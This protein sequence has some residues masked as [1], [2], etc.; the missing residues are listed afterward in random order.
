LGERAIRTLNPSS[1]SSM[2][3]YVLSL[4]AAM[5]ISGIV[6]VSFA[7]KKDAQ[8]ILSVEDFWGAVFVGFLAGYT[9][10]AFLIQA[11]TPGK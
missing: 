3:F 7:R 10:K 9:G 1:P 2:I 4:L 8:P 5:M 6:V 11:I